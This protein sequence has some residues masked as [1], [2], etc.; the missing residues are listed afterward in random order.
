DLEDAVA[1][2]NKARAREV[3]AEALARR[4]RGGK[5]VFVRVNAFETGLTNHDLAAVVGSFPWGV[6]LPKCGSMAEVA[7]LA[8]G[9]DALEAR[10]GAEVGSTRILTVATETAAATLRLGA[11]EA[12]A[13]GRLW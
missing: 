1:P 10:E 13:S 4:D 7:R 5:P 6:V 12:D 11:G 2:E 8:H 3:T 9:L